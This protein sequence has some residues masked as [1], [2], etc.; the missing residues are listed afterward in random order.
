MK[1]SY[2]IFKNLSDGSK[3]IF[4][5]LQKNRAMTKS[6]I[7]EKTQMKLTTLN[8]FMKPL[9][10]NKTIVEYCI[11]ESTGGRKPVIYNINLC[12]F[13]AIG[14][15][16]Q[17]SYV[18]VAFTNL[19]V[20]LLHK[21][22]FQIDKSCSLDKI[23]KKILEVINKVILELRLD[24]LTLFGIGLSVENNKAEI[25]DVLENT[26]RC[27]VVTE[28]AVKAAA[29]VEY[30]YGFKSSLK[31]IGYFDLNSRIKAAIIF[32]GK[33]LNT[34][35]DEEDPFAHMIVKIGKEECACGSFDYIG[36]YVSKASIGEAIENNDDLSKEVIKKAAVIIAIG[37]L[38][39]IRIFN[40]KAV[41]LSGEEMLASEF[42]YNTCVET[43]LKNSL[44]K[45]II[46][47]RGGYF[48]QDAK[49]LGAAAMVVE[50]Y[51]ENY[52]VEEK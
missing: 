44:D 38:N 17:E 23:S 33:I 47:K 6:E 28:N 18:E 21:E 42:F 50:R 43:V 35:E 10:E 26:L 16:V 32:N 37:I 4:N 8:R 49:A 9:E 52:N 30:F 1:C 3:I 48:G 20:E 5:L 46:F 31:N 39:Y 25:K 36:N 24:F 27:P 41:V 7:L 34:A 13:Y 11:G 15:N 12:N 19:R 40:L 14:I 22:K 45:E 2:D 51:L 29:Q